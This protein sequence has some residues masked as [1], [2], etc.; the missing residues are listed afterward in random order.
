MRKIF[1]IFVLTFC[2]PFYSYSQM[3]SQKLVGKGEL[4]YLFWH[5]YDAKL[6]SEDGSFSFD[7]PFTLNLEYKRNIEGEKI[8][9]LSAE[10]IRDLGFKDEVKLA[11]WH[12]QMKDIFP[13][14]SDGDSV[15]GVY[16]PNK[17]TVFYKNNKKIGE[18]KDPDFGKWFFGIWFDKDTSQPKLRRKLLGG[19]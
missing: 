5:V 16:Q 1:F 9:D 2:I 14:I 12:S 10:E 6:Y 7:E 8:A 19:E 17:P 18:V 3:E 11:A 13:D 4:N 15:K